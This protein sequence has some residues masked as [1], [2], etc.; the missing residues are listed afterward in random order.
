[1]EHAL[2]IWLAPRNSSLTIYECWHSKII[3][4]QKRPAFPFLPP[5]RTWAGVMLLVQPLIDIVVVL[6][7]QDFR[8]PVEILSRF[9]SDSFLQCRHRVL[10]SRTR[11]IIYL[12]WFHY[13]ER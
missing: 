10:S 1:M 9:T 2:A 3:S 7:K 5:P 4:T 8:L 13:D 6:G 12:E 11:K